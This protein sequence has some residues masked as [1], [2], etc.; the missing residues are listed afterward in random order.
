MKIHYDVIYAKTLWGKGIFPRKVLG[1]N[2]VL[3]SM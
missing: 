2:L 3:V 1:L